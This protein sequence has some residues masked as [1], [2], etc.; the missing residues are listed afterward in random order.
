MKKLNELYNCSYDCLVKDIKTNS[1]EIEKGDMFVCIKGVNVDRHNYIKEAIEKGC[2]CLI[3]DR[4]SNY[5]VPYIKVEDTNKELGIVSK[6][7]YDYDDSLK[8]IGVT[9]TDGKTTTSS[10][11][12]DMLIECG[13]IGTNGIKGNSLDISSNNTTPDLNLIY[14]YLNV[15][16][17]EKLSY[18]SMEVSSEGLLHNRVYG[19]NF[20]IGVLTNISEDHLN[21]HKTL[22]NY[23]DSK[24]KL[25]KS[26]KESG[27][28][29][30]N[31]DDRFFDK[32]SENCNCNIFSYGKD[33]NS[34]LRID[35]F[36]EKEEETYIRFVYMDKLYEVKSSLKGEYNVYNLMAAISV[37][38]CLGFDLLDIIDRVKNIKQVLGRCELFS[39][40]G[41]NVVLDY[42]H[43]EN[44]LRSI[45]SYLNKIK[46]NRIITV[47]GS[48]GG[49]EREKRK[50][51]GRVV[52]SLSDL[53]IYTM[54]DPRYENVID[55][56]NEMKDDDVNNYMIVEDRRKAIEKAFSLA[57]SNDIIL[58]A[59][60]GR[61]NYMAIE[62]RKENYS[63]YEV[64]RGLISKY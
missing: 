2:S 14:K 44:G 29:I 39:V 7:F 49:R 61:D 32:F 35:S 9:G 63:D 52:Q 30:L 13:Y 8:M 33:K 23:V 20:D 38:I 11:I 5:S 18:V 16:K 17:K 24:I 55:I 1:K 47:T 4:G 46:K 37:L 31:R 50:G 53:V 26:I 59:G 64:I 21:V 60:K 25:F 56:I 58:V 28:A 45:L 43:T 48:A 34:D 6:K 12:R 19:V 62:A 10:I 42:A 22:S 27:Y 3:V 40:G 54:D 36:D 57:K 41:F 51:M 15:F